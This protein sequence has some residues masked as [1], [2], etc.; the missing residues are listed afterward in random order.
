MSSPLP[1]DPTLGGSVR[2]DRRW[3]RLAPPGK[4]RQPVL[5][6]SF[7]PGRGRSMTRQLPARG[8]RPRA[9]DGRCRRHYPRQGQG[10]ATWET[11]QPRLACVPPP[12]STRCRRT[13]PGSAMSPFH[14]GRSEG[15]SPHE[16]IS[17]SGQARLRRGSG[18]PRDVSSLTMVP[19][20]SRQPQAFACAMCHV[21]RCSSRAFLGIGC[22]ACH[23][24]LSVG[25]D[26]ILYERPN[27]RGLRLRAPRSFCCLPCC[28]GNRNDA[29]SSASA[30]P[31]ILDASSRV[32]PD[33]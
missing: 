10:A 32:C 4:C 12:T 22:L 5:G 28:Q 8:R 1:R 20:I 31:R 27:P 18:I 7:K 16:P 33:S 19:G 3:Q 13:V 25:I 21:T 6:Y 11:D 2:T 29:Q 26:D 23:L 17:A 30:G 15:H 9:A 24:A 14:R